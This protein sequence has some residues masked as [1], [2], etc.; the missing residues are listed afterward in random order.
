MCSHCGCGSHPVYGHVHVFVVA[1]NN[2]PPT[3]TCRAAPALGVQIVISLACTKLYS[4]IASPATEKGR[5]L[6]PVTQSFRELEKFEAAAGTRASLSPVSLP[7][8]RV[9][10][11]VIKGVSALEWPGP[12]KSRTQSSGFRIWIWNS[13]LIPPQKHTQTNTNQTTPLHCQKIIFLIQNSIVRKMSCA[14][15]CSVVQC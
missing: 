4:F 8:L 5:P 11:T 9:G 7:S 13:R 12:C 3:K 1:C 14:Q 15:F 2:P 6:T 10:V